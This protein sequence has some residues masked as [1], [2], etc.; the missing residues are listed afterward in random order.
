M[1]MACNC[2]HEGCGCEADA[3]DKVRMLEQ[4]KA[5]LRL[6]I[7]A[8]DRSIGRLKEQKT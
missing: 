7:E 5:M 8:I 4:T 3:E 1:C 2:Y 6:R